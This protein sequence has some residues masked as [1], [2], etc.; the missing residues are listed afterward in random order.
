MNLCGTK[1][2]AIDYYRVRE[3]TRFVILDTHAEK[4]NVFEETKL[5]NK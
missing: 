3:I 1:I 4:S 5:C 2:A